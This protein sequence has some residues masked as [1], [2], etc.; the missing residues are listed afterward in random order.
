MVTFFRMN[1]SSQKSSQHSAT[2]IQPAF[3]TELAGSAD[4]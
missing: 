3:S 1:E 4:H 2:V